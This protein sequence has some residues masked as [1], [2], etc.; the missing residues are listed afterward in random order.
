M[1]FGGEGFVLVLSNT[2]LED[3]ARI[4]EKIRQQVATSPVAPVQFTLSIGLTVVSSL[5][6]DISAASR[7]PTRRSIR[8]SARASIASVAR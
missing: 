5:D 6:Q 3:A 1:R 4:A 2:G 8:P 7:A